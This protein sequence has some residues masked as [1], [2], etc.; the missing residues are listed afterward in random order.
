ML[1]PS[2]PCGRS[3]R[4]LLAVCVPLSVLTL[5]LL[6][7]HLR[8]SLHAPFPPP[9]ARPS[10]RA[11]HAHA[12]TTPF[13]HGRVH[14]NAHRQA[15]SHQAFHGAR[16]Q[17]ALVDLSLRWVPSGRSVVVVGVEYGA[18]VRLFADS[19]LHVTA[20][21]PNARFASL[22]R[23]HADRNVSWNVDIVQAAAG[24][25]HGRA[26]LKYQKEIIDA[27]VVPVDDVVKAP[28]ALLSVDVQGAEDDVIAGARR[29]CAGGVGMVWF[30]AAACNARVANVLSALDEDFV[31]F[32]FVP[33]GRVRNQ[34]A[35]SPSVERQNYEWFPGRPSGFDDYL[36][37]L[38]RAKV[39]NFAFLQTDIVAIRRSFVM[40]VIDEFD[41]I[42]ETVCRDEDA[43][44]VLRKFVM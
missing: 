16:L 19:G 28:V 29:L 13:A 42:G 1:K 20:F 32:D 23:A 31:L 10:A 7:S 15:L 9:P 36:R 39:D 11:P 12:P 26:R 27:Q 3:P 38:C 4:G 24:A 17:A 22:L 14:G 43:K 41:T 5:P 8:L 6:L 30:E 33:W 25:R 21:E 37:W 2:R 34:S 35:D 18:D 40:H 44:C